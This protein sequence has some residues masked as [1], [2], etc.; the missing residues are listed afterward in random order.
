MASERNAFA[1]GAWL[2]AA[3]ASL[4]F[5]MLIGV[6]A[7]ALVYFALLAGWIASGA[8]GAATVEPSRDLGHF[9]TALLALVT[10]RVLA[11]IA[12]FATITL[13][14]ALVGSAACGS[15]AGFFIA[16]A[17]ARA[18]DQRTFLLREN[19]G[20]VVGF[21]AASALLFLSVRTL[22]AL[23]LA[24]GLMLLAMRVRAR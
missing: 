10:T 18:A 16:S 24:S 11:I 5:A 8:V 14:A 17:G 15:Y 2:G 20:F 19:N 6:G 21:A 7:S 12:P 13:I 23:V 1:T 4:G 9:V 22:D 3:Q